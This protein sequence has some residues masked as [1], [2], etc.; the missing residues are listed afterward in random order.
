MSVPYKVDANKINHNPSTRIPAIARPFL[1]QR[2]LSTLDILSRFIEEECVPADAVYAAQIKAAGEADVDR[3][4]VQGRFGS[5]PA[6]IEDLKAQARTLG[7]WNLW[8]PK[9]HGE[10]EGE[11]GSG[12]TNVEYALMAEV[13]GKSNTGSEVCLLVSGMNNTAK[14]KPDPDICYG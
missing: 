9:G 2:A 7:L 6:V 5:H 14:R 1:S 13:M 8:I 10:Q 3:N 12:F 4:I 11:A